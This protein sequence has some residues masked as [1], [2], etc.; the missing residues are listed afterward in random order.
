MNECPNC[1]EVEGRWQ[2]EGIGAYEFWGAKS[3]DHDWQYVC[4]YC[5]E[6]LE[7]EYF[8]PQQ[9]RGAEMADWL[10][11]QRQEENLHLSI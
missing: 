11:D 5:E 4:P 6:Y 7:H 3:I 10:Y 9:A 8:D 1:G 2:D